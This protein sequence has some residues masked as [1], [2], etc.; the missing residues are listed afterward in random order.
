MVQ[1]LKLNKT[2]ESL[3]LSDNNIGDI[4]GVKCIASLLKNNS[5]LKQLALSIFL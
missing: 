2:L 4:K 3:F 1:A 5:T